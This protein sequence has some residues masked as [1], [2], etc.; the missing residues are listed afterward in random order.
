MS[1]P[2]SQ[3]RNKTPADKLRLRNHLAL[4]LIAFL[5]LLSQLVVQSALRRLETDAPVIKLAG[6]QIKLSKQIAKHAMELSVATTPARVIE[7]TQEIRSQFVQWKTVHRAL[8]QGDDGLQIPAHRSPRLQELFTKVDPIQA[9]MAASISDML[10]AVRKS[11]LTKPERLRVSWFAA[12]I[13]AAEEIYSDRMEEVLTQYESEAQGRLAWMKRLELA[14]MSITLLALLVEAVLVFR[15]ATQMIRR[16]IA[17]LQEQA[18]NLQAARLQAEAASRAKTCFLTNMS[19]E[20]RTPMTAILG[21][22]DMLRDPNLRPNDAARFIDRI[23]T[24]GQHL[25]M[26]INSILDLAASEAGELV[27]NRVRC[28]PRQIIGDVIANYAPRATAKDIAL[29]LSCRGKLPTSVCTDPGRLR[30][31]VTHLIDNAIKFTRQGGVTVAISLP[32]PSTE[33]LRIDVVDTG[34]G[35]SPELQQRLFSPFVQA[36]ESLTRKEGG[37]GVELALSK[38]IAEALGGDITVNSEP[39]QGTT[40]TVHIGTGSLAGVEMVTDHSAGMPQPMTAPPADVAVGR[41]LLV[42]DDAPDIQR[43]LHFVLTKSGATV[44]VAHHGEAGVAAV[45]EAA[46]R[47]QDFDLVFM[48]MQM[49]VLDGYA[50]TARLRELGCTLPIIAVTA[51]AM[52][53]EREKCIAAGC[54]DYT[55]KPV[56]RNRLMEMIH[57]YVPSRIAAA[58]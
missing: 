25:T 1:K 32:D 14:L 12:K 15:P 7:T 47:G 31:I 35:I 49:P 39:G 8:E 30:T 58:A 45:L 18:V 54:T 5:T 17:A 22:A 51:H 37:L 52:A 46:Q 3:D 42:V 40:F 34:C 43:L 41:R 19:H 9:G 33:K 16:Q 6:D 2:A 38:R 10:A 20:I 28:N 44:A 55:T 24:Q 56:E 26:L 48:D 13:S 27:I 11:E 23:H 36:D 53:G 29:T 4:G 50:A 57:K 21:Y